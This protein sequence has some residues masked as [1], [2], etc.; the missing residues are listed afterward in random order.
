MDGSP[1]Q[2]AWAEKIIAYKTKGAKTSGIDET[3]WKTVVDTIT[4][5]YGARGWIDMRDVPPR[6]LVNM[7]VS[8]AAKMAKPAESPKPA[9]Q[10]KPA[11]PAVI[12]KRPP[13]KTAEEMAAEA[14]KQGINPEVAAKAAG[15]QKWIEAANP[16]K[17]RSIQTFVTPLIQNAANAAKRGNNELALKFL[18]RAE[19]ELTRIIPDARPA[20]VPAPAPE[21]PKAV[22]ST[23]VQKPET[24]Q[25]SPWRIDE[26]TWAEGDIKYL[27]KNIETAE[28]GILKDFPILREHVPRIV[29]SN[30]LTRVGA[31]YAPLSR[32]IILSTEKGRKNTWQEETARERELDT[33]GGDIVLRG[34]VIRQNV[35]FHSGDFE[36][37][38]LTHEFGHAIA[39]HH[40]LVGKFIL[41]EKPFWDAFREKYGDKFGKFDKRGH[42]TADF[43]AKNAPSR[44]GTTNPDEIIAESFA[45]YYT[46]QKPSEFSRAIVETYKD[47]YNASNLN[48]PRSVPL[49]DV[50]FK[51]KAEIIDKFGVDTIRKYLQGDDSAETTELAK[52]LGV[53]IPAPR[54]I[55]NTAAEIEKYAG[56]SAD[57]LAAEYADGMAKIIARNAEFAIV[58]M[59]GEN[60]A[61]G[62]AARKAADILQKRA[63][64]WTQTVT[65][66]IVEMLTEGAKSSESPLKVAKELENAGVA[67]AETVAR[68]EMARAR[69][70]ANLDIMKA[71]NVEKVQFIASEDERMCPICGQY[72]G[73]VYDVGSAPVL[74]LHPN[75]RCTLVPYIDPNELKNI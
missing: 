6:Q 60:Y 72:H 70:M 2:V 67:H 56:M 5:K 30:R 55:F 23:V 19:G 27:Q 52:F 59:D 69:E 47:L 49:L 11:E 8:R 29:P 10:V 43:L 18:A 38:I 48:S 63:A 39:R 34:K 33:E 45:D 26:S 61:I 22:E 31:K 25:K 75:C 9:E 3:D 28:K 58:M 20:P 7:F 68:T 44:Y 62:A 16:D 21:P 41:D 51:R 15:L 66:N 65:E 14:V 57:Q 50:G 17:K 1:K 71:Q 35:P 24:K 37:N 46:S 74:P 4:E 73:K 12:P 40:Q 36:T 32:E 54:K 64:K 13:T 53:D 42:L